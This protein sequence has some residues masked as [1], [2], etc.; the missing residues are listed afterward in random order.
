MPNEV[1]DVISK[2]DKVFVDFMMLQELRLP[3]DPDPW[4]LA[5]QGT[6]MTC[7]FVCFGTLPLLAYVGGKGKDAE[8]HFSASCAIVVA[9]LII[10]GSIK[11]YLTSMSITRAALTMLF[12]GAVSGS[13]SYGFAGLLKEALSQ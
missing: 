11:G 13:V 1:V 10:L 4:G 3:V 12:S 9:A 6:A 7:S 5:K 2:D 8:L